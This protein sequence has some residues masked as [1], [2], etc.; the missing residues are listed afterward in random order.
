[1]FELVKF[2]NFT[3]Q[4]FDSLFLLDAIQVDLLVKF[5]DRSF[6]QDQAAFQVFLALGR[7]C[8]G[9]SEHGIIGKYFTLNDHQAI[10][11]LIV[12]S[13][14]LRDVVVQPCGLF[15]GSVQLLL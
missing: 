13:L 1:M 2:F 4:I 11:E 9:V 12:G 8:R 3:Y 10:I 6:R 5:E 7:V 15:L 14:E